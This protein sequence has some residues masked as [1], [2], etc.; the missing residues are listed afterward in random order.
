MDSSDKSNNE[1]KDNIRKTFKS[2]DK[3]KKI[4][5]DFFLQKTF[6]NIYNL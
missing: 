6:S 4:K 1:K 2:K 5:S 3:L